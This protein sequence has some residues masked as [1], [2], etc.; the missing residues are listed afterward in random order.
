MLCCARKG[1]F[2]IGTVFKLSAFVEAG[3]EKVE[4]ERVGLGL[5]LVHSGTTLKKVV[6]LLGKL[7]GAAV[8]GEIQSE[9]TILLAIGIVK[10]HLGVHLSFRNPDAR[11]E[12]SFAAGTIA[13]NGYPP[14][15]KRVDLVI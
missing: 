11:T 5:R 8:G 10:G 4:A 1:S 6:L 13:R 2:A 7:C 15:G 3:E 14:T 9:Q 12:N